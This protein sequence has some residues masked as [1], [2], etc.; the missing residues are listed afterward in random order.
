MDLLGSP[1]TE[2]LDM[3]NTDM[4][5]NGGDCRGVHMRKS[6]AGVHHACERHRCS[7]LT[8]PSTTMRLE[9]MGIK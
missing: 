8:T 7:R 6:D 1:T 3:M 4:I 2:S 9:I 5:L